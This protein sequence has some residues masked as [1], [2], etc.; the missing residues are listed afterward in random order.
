MDFPEVSGPISGLTV[1]LFSKSFQ[2]AISIYHM[3]FNSHCFANL[4]DCFLVSVD[5]FGQ[6]VSCFIMLCLVLITMLA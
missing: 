4:R 6:I 2:T 5:M 1:C 3:F